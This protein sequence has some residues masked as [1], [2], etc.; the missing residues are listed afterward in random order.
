MKKSEIIRA[1]KNNKSKEEIAKLI[2]SPE[3]NKEIVKGGRI[4]GDSAGYICTVSG[5]T[6][7]YISCNPRDWF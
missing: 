3:V 1:W 5:E 7:P 2:G 6:W 4:S